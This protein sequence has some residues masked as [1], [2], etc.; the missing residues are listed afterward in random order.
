LMQTMLDGGSG[1]SEGHKRNCILIACYLGL[2][3]HLIESIPFG[4]SSSA[5]SRP[6]HT[7]GRRIT[8]GNFAK[9]LATHD[10][11]KKYKCGLC[12][13]EDNRSDNF[14]KHEKS[15]QKRRTTH[16]LKDGLKSSIRPPRLA[17]GAQPQTNSAFPNT[18]QHYHLNKISLGNEWP[19]PVH[20]SP[21]NPEP[22]NTSFNSS[23][24]YTDTRFP[25]TLAAHIPETLDI[26]SFP[27]QNDWAADLFNQTSILAQP[28]CARLEAGYQFSP[29]QPSIT[30][31]P[32]KNDLNDW[33]SVQY[34]TKR[35][36]ISPEAM[37][38]SDHATISS[39]PP[40]AAA[41]TTMYDASLNIQSPSSLDKFLDALLQ[42]PDPGVDFSGQVANPYAQGNPYHLPTASAP[43]I[44]F[45]SEPA[46]E[47][48][49]QTSPSG[50]SK[51]KSPSYPSDD[52]SDRAT[53]V[54][55]GY[56]GQSTWMDSFSS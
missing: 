43:F 41:N 40:Q 54:K 39:T 5:K 14:V 26:N 3:Q 7:C 55:T 35:E 36:A 46:Y 11:N 24:P 51:R 31:L 16:D 8:L 30:Q 23:S 27:W 49:L 42:L 52:G 6:C 10:P 44:P 19:M 38:W 37:S 9:H 28:Y 2:S 4:S 32:F 48:S 50:S 21:C 22:M 20:Q 15:C 47:N 13:H 12:G 18:L 53:R 17:E 1:V 33:G 25:P 56:A 34:S 45:A 29:D